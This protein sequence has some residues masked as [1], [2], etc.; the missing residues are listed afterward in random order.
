MH[1]RGRLQLHCQ[2]HCNTVTRPDQSLNLM[3]G[4][5]GW[6]WAL[7]HFAP[8]A[9][10]AGADIYLVHALW[11]AALI[12]SAM[13]TLQ[14]S[15]PVYDEHCQSRSLIPA[16]TMLRPCS[17]H[18]HTVLTPFLYLANFL[19]RQSKPLAPLCW[20]SPYDILVL[21]AIICRTIVWLW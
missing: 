18:A 15:L 11:V 6:A 20:H 1:G 12:L 13:S 21:I 10:S 14:P 9:A 19:T 2:A 8:T 3:L 7:T 4:W 16:H 17:H 5:A